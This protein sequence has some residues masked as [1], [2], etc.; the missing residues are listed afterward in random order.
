MKDAIVLAHW[1]CQGYKAEQ[2][3]DLFDFCKCLTERCNRLISDE[4]EKRLNI[5]DLARRI[6][7]A[8][9]DVCNTIE[10]T[11]KPL[12][13]ESGYC[14][15]QFQYSHGLSVYFPWTRWM[16]AA[17]VDDLRH[18][19]SLNF[20]LDTRWDEFLDVYTRKTQRP[21]RGG[22]QE[23]THESALNRRDWLFTG[24]PR[25]LRDG[26][27][28][29]PRGELKLNKGAKFICSIASAQIGGRDILAKNGDLGTVTVTDGDIEVIDRKLTV[30]SGAFEVKVGKAV[31]EGKNGS[32]TLSDGLFKI[33]NGQFDLF[34]KRYSA[35]DGE[36]TVKE[37][38]VVKDGEFTVK[39]G[40]F[41]VKDGEFTVKD[42][43]FTV[44][45]GEY[46]V[47]DGEFTVKDGEF[48]VKDGE[49]TVKDGEFTVKDGEFTVKDG[50]FTVKDGEFTVKDGE[51]TVKDGEF[52]VKGATAGPSKIATMKNPPFCW[53]DS[54]L[55]KEYN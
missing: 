15:S 1:E 21:V 4:P 24:R 22:I 2:N 31:T 10:E 27:F 19:Q 54:K 16:D 20:A 14:G 37:T 33:T 41:T 35:K 39:D 9:Q 34:D 26:R 47:K 46:T 50:E 51:F 23:D 17:G 29:I 45:D 53:N 6:K 7:A 11:N 5:D 28:R 44:K 42:G 13:I 12:V 43:D 38:Y 8:C 32:F 52:T 3:V 48:T 55:I 36:F 25:G 18:Y 30:K 40:E 49:F